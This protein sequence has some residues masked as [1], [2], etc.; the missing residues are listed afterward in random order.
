MTQSKACLAIAAYCVDANIRFELRVSGAI[1][2]LVQLMK[3]NKDEVRFNACWAITCC[4]SDYLTAVEF[5]RFE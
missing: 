1:P 3:S 4:S 5:C 2:I